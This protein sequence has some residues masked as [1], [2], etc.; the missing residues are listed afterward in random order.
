ME[1]VVIDLE[2]IPKTETASFWVPKMIDGKE[3]FPPLHVHKICC[4]GYCIL[5][6]NDM[7]IEKPIVEYGSLFDYSLDQPNLENEKDIISNFYQM[8]DGMDRFTLITWNGRTFD[9]PVLV[10]RMYSYGM[11]LAWYYRNKEI[12]GRYGK[13]HI[14]L[15]DA[16]CNYGTFGHGRAHLDSVAKLS[17]LPGKTD[18][19]GDNVKLMHEQ[20]KYEDIQTYCLTDVIQ[21]ALI[22]LRLSVL[23][24]GMN[25]DVFVMKSKTLFNKC[26]ND[27]RGP[28]KNIFSNSDKKK[29]MMRE[30]DF[31]I[32]E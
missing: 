28:I 17:G 29:F 11:D 21:T 13:Q 15:M 1:Y 20:G 19:K 32:N 5:R 18:V 3:E 30:C 12:S 2:T 24:G 27:S 14:D 31:S 22:F 26:Q 10:H 16:F 7:A 8:I 6:D 25:D 9:L 23:S 4:I